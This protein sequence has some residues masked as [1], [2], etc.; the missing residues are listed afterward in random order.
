MILV[1]GAAGLSG[2]T[3]ARELA[4]QGVPARLLVRDRAKA[5]K[6]EHLAG[7]EI[8]EGDMQRRETLGPA[9]ANVD[10][11]LMISSAN[12]EL[13]ETQCGFIDACVAAGVRHVIK[14][15]GAEPDFD[16]QKFLFTR[17][18]EAIEDHLEASGLAWTH[19]RPSQ[20]MQVYLRELPNM[21]SE[22]AFYLPF[23]D[24]QLAP[25]DLLDV[26]RIA[27]ALLRDGG[28][29]G[30]SFDMTGPEAL[31]MTDIAERFSTVAGRT[32]RYVPITPEQRSEALLR[33]GVSSYFVDAL[34]D[35]THER[36][37]HKTS[38]T[39]LEAHRVFGVAPTPF[40]EFAKR[41]A[42]L[43]RAAA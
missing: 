33:Q 14:F 35:Q 22:N 1:T 24:I 11:V 16:P 38:R 7:L 4:R 28:H 31:T 27:T 15:S 40:S 42:D 6:I 19:L 32:I 36:L 34:N 2:S 20:F 37:R 21:N 9:L 43:L 17:M 5:T 30:R 39:C 12:R 25:I 26:A 41:Y 10:R 3:V 29:E 23:D 18:H 13:V 8:V